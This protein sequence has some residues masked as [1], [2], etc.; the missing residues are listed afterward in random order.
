[1]RTRIFTCGHGISRILFFRN[2]GVLQESLINN[3]RVYNS[4]SLKIFSCFLVCL[5]SGISFK[6][7]CLDCLGHVVKKQGQTKLLCNP[8]ILMY[9][10]LSQTA[11]H[12]QDGRYS[13]QMS[14]FSLGPQWGKNQ[15]LAGKFNL[16]TAFLAE[17]PDV[18]C[19]IVCTAQ[20][21]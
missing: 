6:I 13:P 2:F 14:S 5:Y 3:P 9:F 17:I 11:F 15:D 16:W 21:K 8:S 20:Y 10:C 1:M 18:L 12:A 4:D 7:S 19:E